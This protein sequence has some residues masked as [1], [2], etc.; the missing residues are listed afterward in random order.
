MDSSGKDIHTGLGEVRGA[1]A[2]DVA[3]VKDLK[4][5][6]EGLQ[7]DLAEARKRAQTAEK[8]AFANAE[9]LEELRETMASKDFNDSVAASSQVSASTN[10]QLEHLREQNE[11]LTARERNLIARIE[12]MEKEFER[13][14]TEKSFIEDRY[15]KLDEQAPSVN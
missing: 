9:K 7:L 1:D 13:H 11:A 12:V 2:R 14:L 4:R 10:A 8:L 3:L 5:M 6:T 15:V